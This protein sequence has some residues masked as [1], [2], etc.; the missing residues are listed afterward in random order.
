MC[1]MCGQCVSPHHRRISEKLILSPL[2]QGCSPPVCHSPAGVL[3]CTVYC[4]PR[5]LY[6]APLYCALSPAPPAWPTA[7]PTTAEKIA[8]ELWRYLLLCYRQKISKLVSNKVSSKVHFFYSSWI[9]KTLSLLSAVSAQSSW[10]LVK[11]S[12]PS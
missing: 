8:T 11:F 9:D 10:S 12:V 5:S 7:A 4:A 1:L 6:C 2:C 3:C